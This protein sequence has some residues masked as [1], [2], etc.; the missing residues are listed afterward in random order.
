MYEIRDVK[1]NEI[2]S[3]KERMKENVKPQI[4]FPK[5]S[6]DALNTCSQR[7]KQ[8]KLKSEKEHSCQNP[9]FDLLNI[10]KAVQLYLCIYKCILFELVK[11]MFFTKLKSE[12]LLTM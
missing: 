9:K 7:T 6:Q 1:T 2:Q 3:Q 4:A 8:N 12:G 5:V 11:K 10:K